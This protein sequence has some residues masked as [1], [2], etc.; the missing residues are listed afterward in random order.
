M[1]IITRMCT[2]MLL[3][4]LLVVIAALVESVVHRKGCSNCAGRHWQ[5]IYFQ[6]IDCLVCSN[7]WVAAT[8]DYKRTL[9]S[10]IFSGPTT[11]IMQG[12]IVFN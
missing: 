2:C 3:F 5:R 7:C 11:G 10:S 1:G 9:F 4:V 6:A 12:L 8:C